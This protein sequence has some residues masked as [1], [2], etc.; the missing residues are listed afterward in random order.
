MTGNP[1][2]HS[3]RFDQSAKPFRFLLWLSQPPKLI[4]ASDARKHRTRQQCKPPTSRHCYFA[5][6]TVALPPENP[7][8]SHHSDHARSRGEKQK[9]RYDP[10]SGYRWCMH[11]GLAVKEGRKYP[12]DKGRLFIGNRNHRSVIENRSSQIS[13]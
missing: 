9:F 10:V 1:H 3:N 13:H 7:S 4:E 5:A 11:G 12:N 6:P 2:R 8:G